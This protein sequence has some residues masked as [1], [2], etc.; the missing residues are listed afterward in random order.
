MFKKIGKFMLWSTLIVA[1]GAFVF[2]SSAHVPTATLTKFDVGM[3]AAA[4]AAGWW[5]GTVG[6]AL[7]VIGAVMKLFGYIST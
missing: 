6:L 3:Q 2:I 1:A 4:V 7:L 5:I